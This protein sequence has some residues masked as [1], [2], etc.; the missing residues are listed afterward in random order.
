MVQRAGMLIA[1]YKILASINSVF[2]PVTQSTVQSLFGPL[3][4]AFWELGLKKRGK[5]DDTLDIAMNNKLSFVT[6]LKHMWASL[7]AQMVKN[8]PVM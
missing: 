8:L 6:D 4:T 7:V 1:H 5:N 3:F 2:F